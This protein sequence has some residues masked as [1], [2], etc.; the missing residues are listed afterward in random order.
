M[1]C[2]WKLCNRFK[3]SLINIPYAKLHQ[4]STRC[5]QQRNAE[6]RLIPD[7]EVQIRFSFSG[8]MGIRV[9]CV[10]PRLAQTEYTYKI[11]GIKCLL[12][13][14]L[15]EITQRCYGTRTWQKERNVILNLGTWKILWRVPNFKGRRYILF[16]A[17]VEI[18]TLPWVEKRR[19]DLC[20]NMTRW[21]VF[22][23]PK[24]FLMVTVMTV[25]TG[26]EIKL[27]I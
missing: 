23:R 13:N 10:V 26:P 8:D 1:C 4:Y 3:L 7:S 19:Q 2:Y 18:I 27:T 20:I 9:S 17:F 24:T 22:V 12:F 25:N 16:T 14:V 6:S 15:G 5:C 21:R 11:N